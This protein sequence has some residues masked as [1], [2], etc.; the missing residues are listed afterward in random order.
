MSVTGKG[1]AGGLFPLLGCRA[2]VSLWHWEPL[3]AALSAHLGYQGLGEAV[4]VSRGVTGFCLSRGGHAHL[5]LP[6]AVTSP[7]F[8]PLQ[9]PWRAE[10]A[11]RGR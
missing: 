6:V 1:G 5:D 7:C 2:G 10:R 11:G 3:C 4:Q 9:G 8:V